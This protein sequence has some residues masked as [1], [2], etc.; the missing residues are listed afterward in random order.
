MKREQDG[1]I[2]TQFDYPA[3]EA[4]G[5]IKMDFLGLRNLTVLDDARRQHPGQPRRGTRPGRPA[6]RRPRVLR[7]ARTRRLVGCLPA[8]RWPAALAHATDAPGQLRGHLRAHRAVPA[9]SDGRRLAH[10][11]RAA[12]DRPPRGHA[13][14][15]RARR[16][17]AGHP[18]HELRP[19]HLPG[20]GHGDR[21]ARRRLLP[22]TGRHPAAR[23]GQEE[24]VRARQAVRG[25]RCR[26]EGQRATPTAASRR[27]G[28]SCCR[29]PTTRSTRHTRP[30]TA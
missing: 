21:P 10:Q 2:I 30:P 25:F 20:A 26:H 7:T 19:D 17:A 9:G 14:P 4:L 22:R 27:S 15:S 16:V 1:A 24:E 18:R 23:D 29:S 12:Q 6:A 13:D 11:L 8:R 5:L 28:T 3:C